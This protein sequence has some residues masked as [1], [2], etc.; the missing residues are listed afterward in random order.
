MEKTVATLRVVGIMEGISFILLLFVAMPLKYMFAIPM[1]VKIIGM[2]HGLLFLW[3]LWALYEAS[4]KHEWN[5]KFRLLAFIASLLP[6]GT[7]VLDKKLLKY[8]EIAKK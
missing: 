5:Y 4:S 6:F 2:A 8:Q 7:F 1:A 3:F